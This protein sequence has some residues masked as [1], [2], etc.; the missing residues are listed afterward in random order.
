MELTE[1]QLALIEEAKKNL[2]VNTELLAE[3]DKSK[4][5]K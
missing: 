5:E 2:K 1:E 4:K 3:V